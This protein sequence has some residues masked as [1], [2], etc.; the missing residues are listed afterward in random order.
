[1]A[2]RQTK[3]RPVAGRGHGR[4]GFGFRW[5]F[6]GVML[7]IFVG[8]IYLASTVIRGASSAVAS[9]TDGSPASSWKGSERVNVLLMGVDKR[10]DDSDD[11]IRSDSMLVV[12]VDPKSKSASIISIPRD[13]YVSIPVSNNRSIDDRIN[14]AWVYAASEKY[15]G[16]GPALA[17]KTVSQTL[18]VP[19]HYSA[20][21]DFQGFVRVVDRLGGLSIDVPAPLK[22]NEYPTEDYRVQRIYFAPGLQHMDGQ[23]ALIYARS[24]HQDSDVYRAS[25]QQE[26]LLAAR[27]QFLT[28]DLLPK[29]PALITE[30]RDTVKTDVPV[31]DIV[32]LANLAKDIDPRAIS[33][34]TVPSTPGKTATGAEVLFVDK[35][36]LSRLVAETFNGTPGVVEPPAS[37]EVLNG[38]TTPLLATKW[39]GVFTSNGLT[40]ARFDTAEQA[41]GLETHIYAPSVN[42]PTAERIADLLG[43][44]RSRILDKDPASSADIRVILGKETKIPASN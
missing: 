1:M 20:W 27:D 39:A 12:S 18:G 26:V 44:P 34:K 11:L 13:L 36:G 42:R 15:P 32:S 28:L 43:I 8:G 30:F 21:I 7:G 6:A 4:R 37:V 33:V 41:A 5:L 9:W 25:R 38:T 29:L 24:R 2:R 19:I 14:A 23:R 10:E 40:V 35:K 22:D 17:K 3:G 16:G 31:N